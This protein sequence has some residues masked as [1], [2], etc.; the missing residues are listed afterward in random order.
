M[1]T[2]LIKFILMFI[3]LSSFKTASAQTRSLTLEE[4]LAIADRNNPELK[5][6]EL[7]VA[8][9]EE[10]KRELRAAYFPQINLSSGFTLRN[11]AQY[12]RIISDQGQDVIVKAGND[13]LVEAQLEVYQL[14]YDFGETSHSVKAEGYEKQAQA[15]NKKDKRLIIYNRIKQQFYLSISNIRIDRIYIENV[16]RSEILKQIA[17]K[18]VEAGAAIETDVLRAEVNLQNARVREISARNAWQKSL[19]ELIP[20]LGIEEFD[21]ITR[22][23][24]PLI[25]KPKNI[26][27]FT[28]NAVEEALKN[29]HDL[30]QLYLLKKKQDELTASL[31]S[32]R[33]PKIYMNGNIAYNAPNLENKYWNDADLGLKTY[34]GAVSL[35]IDL[36]LFTGGRTTSQINQN[37]IKSQI[38]IERIRDLELQI[39]KQVKIAFRNLSDLWAVLESAQSSSVSAA[40]N[41]N[42]MKINYE[43]G[44][45]SSLEY[46]D[47]L[48][49]MAAAEVLI[50]R[51][52]LNILQTV[53][54][55]ER[56]TG[57]E[58]GFFLKD[59]KNNL[60]GE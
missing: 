3:V 25:S 52:E 30:K 44:A 15:E 7:A 39:K 55:L 14:L 18:R 53:L 51:S 27:K 2:R 19:Y 49:A 40:K 35:R 11:E 33:W 46:T 22:G 1:R 8:N 47:S 41:L 4:C 16:K 13:K 21:F 10:R 45:A 31:R 43:N 6:V 29:R 24:I 23:T 57:S 32:S 42:Q 48:N 59:S 37:S 5:Q 50:V 34:N 9:S 36:P 28:D 20:L 56:I 26:L 54:D 58:T 38:I 60:E 17:A 12:F